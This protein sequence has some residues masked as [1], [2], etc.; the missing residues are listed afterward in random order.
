MVNNPL[1]ATSHIE[2][3]EW[4]MKVLNQP[5]IN[6]VVVVET[7]WSNVLKIT[8]LQGPVYLPEFAPSFIH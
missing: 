4:A 3:I 7:P 1:T 6:T 2:A 8:T 5:E